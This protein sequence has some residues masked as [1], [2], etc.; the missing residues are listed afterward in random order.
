MT[1]D[2]G[3]LSLRPPFSPQVDQISSGPLVWIAVFPI[4]EACIAGSHTE[5]Y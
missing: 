1:D 4:L 5:T 2:R 3:R